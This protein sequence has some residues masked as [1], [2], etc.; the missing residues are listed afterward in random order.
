MENMQSLVD[1]RFI[2]IKLE[3]FFCKMSEIRTILPIR[4]A[5]PTVGNFQRRGHAL[6]APFGARIVLRRFDIV[7][8]KK[9][10][11]TSAS[12]SSEMSLH[13]HNINFIFQKTKLQASCMLC[14]A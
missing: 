14:G 12:F 9:E 2:S 4:L 7:K 8:D 6:R 13:E 1:C 11:K 10:K 5:D 3:G